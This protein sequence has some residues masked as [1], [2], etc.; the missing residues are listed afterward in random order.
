MASWP[1]HHITLLITPG[2]THTSQ[3]LLLLD[4][5]SNCQKSFF[6]CYKNTKWIQLLL[7]S[8]MYLPMIHFFLY[9]LRR[10]V[11]F[12]VKNYTQLQVDGMRIQ[13]VYGNQCLYEVYPDMGNLLSA[14]TFFKQTCRNE[15]ILG[16]VVSSLIFS[17]RFHSLLYSFSFP[18]MSIYLFSQKNLFS[19]KVR[20][21][22]I[23]ILL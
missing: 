12:K 9:R 3:I 4:S 8:V 5:S 6:L 20:D 23:A 14:E 15:V 1:F 11:A 10:M 16:S 17:M 7:D 13:D 2:F 22:V 18:C 21:N 19:K